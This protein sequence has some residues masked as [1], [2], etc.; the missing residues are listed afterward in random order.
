M[1]KN[2]FKKCMIT[3]VA[4]LTAAFMLPGPSALADEGLSDVQET[5]VLEVEED[6]EVEETETEAKIENEV[7][8]E[9]LEDEAVA[10]DAAADEVEDLDVVFS[11]EMTAE[12][13][14]AILK[15][16][17]SFSRRRS[18]SIDQLEESISEYFIAEYGVRKSFYIVQFI[19]GQNGTVTGRTV[20]VLMGGDAEKYLK[21]AA[22][23]FVAPKA[24]PRSG[25]AFDFW[26][27]SDSDEQ[28]QAEDLADI[29]F[30]DDTTMYAIFSEDK[31]GDGIPDRKQDQYDVRFG[32]DSTYGS[33]TGR[34]TFTVFASGQGEPAA[35]GSAP[36]FKVPGVQANYGYAFDKWYIYTEVEVVDF[37]KQMITDNVWIQAGFAI[38]SN[39]DGIPD[40]KQTFYKVDFVAGNGGSLRGEPSSYSV[41]AK[42]NGDPSYIIEDGIYGELY[43][44]AA[45]GYMFRYW[46]DHQGNIISREPYTKDIMH[47]YPITSDAVIVAVFAEDRNGDGIPDDEQEFF[48]V[49]FIAGQ[50]GSICPNGTF[51]LATNEKGDYPTLGMN[52]IRPLA[53]GN[54][55]Y[56][57]TYWMD[58]LGNVY[59]TSY[60]WTSH[61]IKE[62][63]V[64]VAVFE[65]DINMDG[66][67]DSQQ[68][69]SYARFEVENPEFGYLSGKTEFMYFW[70]TDKAA[71]PHNILENAFGGF[72]LPKAVAKD[73]YEAIWLVNDQQVR[74]DFNYL[75]F[76]KPGTI[77][78]ITCR[79]VPMPIPN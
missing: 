32:A 17:N 53:W 33:L 15:I 57:F 59:D 58:H 21:D 35:I 14:A 5:E 47:F 34:T 28:Y 10:D 13:E 29:P 38:D 75:Q 67:A 25:Y 77:L 31:N 71:L 68:E 46:M 51:T 65:A 23:G 1:R 37:N 7:E 22:G 27:Q 61:T 4:A 48:T 72:E 40:Y 45:D 62:N 44:N 56:V 79:F 74:G 70:P 19:A 63:S 26:Q 30:I 41:L 69:I 3:F 52:G 42:E 6:K 64:Y 50:N 18:A 12:D 16:V 20:Y 36:G 39:H 24:N 73:G 11:D 55:G 60:D 66:I 76:D 2:L 49:D 43:A 54:E 78:V 9:E 8:A